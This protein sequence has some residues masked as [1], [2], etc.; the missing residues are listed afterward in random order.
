MFL[1]CSEGR[2]E[3][4]RPV[5]GKVLLLMRGVGASEAWYGVGCTG[6]GSAVTNSTGVGVAASLP[7][8]VSVLTALTRLDLTGNKLSPNSGL[9]ADY[10]ALTGLR[11]VGL[12]SM[13]LEAGPVPSSGFPQEWSSLVDL[14]QL[15]LSN[16]RLLGGT[17]PA[18]WDILASVT[19]LNIANTAACGDIPPTLSNST[20]PSTLDSYC[21]LVNCRRYLA[22][23]LQP[24]IDSQVQPGSAC[25]LTSAWPSSGRIDS[26]AGI[27][28]TAT[29]VTT[30]TPINDVMSFVLNDCYANNSNSLNVV[31]P[32]ELT[33]FSSLTELQFMRNNAAGSLPDV[34]TQLTQL[35]A[36][37]LADNILSGS[38]PASY[39]ALTGLTILKVHNNL[40]TSS[41]PPEWQAMS[42][43]EE[44][45]IS[46]NY[47]LNGT[48]PSAW[49]NLT[50]LTSFWAWGVGAG[51][52]LPPSF[53]ALS[54]L[55][56]LTFVSDTL[57]GSLPS[58]W[59]TLT[60]LTLL[61]IASDRATS[62]MT[63]TIPDVWF[64]FGGA[65]AMFALQDI[66]ISNT[67]VSGGLPTA[68]WLVTSLTKVDFSFNRLYGGASPTGFPMDYS[69]LTGLVSL[70]LADNLFLGGTV[71]SDWAVTPGSALTYLNLQNTGVCE[72]F[73]A[74]LSSAL[75]PG[76]SVNSYCDD[77]SSAYNL[78]TNFKPIFDSTTPGVGC[79]LASWDLGANPLCS[80]TWSGARCQ[81]SPA[82]S[83]GVSLGSLTSLELLNCNAGGSPVHFLPRSLTDLGGS[84]SRLAISNSAVTGTL[85]SEMVYLG[86]LTDLDL[87]GLYSLIQLN[88]GSMGLLTGPLPDS[89]AYLY[90]LEDLTI[91][92]NSLSGTLP[93]SWS[94]IYRLS[95]LVLGAGGN[96]GP[97]PS[98]N[99]AI[100]QE[101]FL[102]APLPYL[103]NLRISNTKV[104]GPLPDPGSAFTAGQL[105]LT[106]LD[107][108]SN[109]LS[110]TLPDSYQGFS[111]PSPLPPSPS[112]FAAAGS[113]VFIDVN[114]Q[115]VNL[116]DVNQTKFA[117]QSCTELQ[118][119][120]AAFNC[121]NNKLVSG[122]IIG[123][124]VLT[125]PP[126]TPLDVFYTVVQTAVT[127]DPASLFSGSFLSAPSPFAAAG[128]DVFFDVT[129]QGVNLPDV[130]QTKFAQQS[131]TELQTSTAAF[132]CV[133]NKLVSG[134]IIGG[135]VLTAPPGTPLDVFYSA[136]QTAVTTDPASL[137][138]GSFLSAYGILSVSFNVF[139]PSAL[140][141]FGRITAITFVH[142]AAIPGVVVA[143]KLVYGSGSA[144][145]TDV[146]A[147]SVY[148]PSSPTLSLST[149]RLVSSGGSALQTLSVCCT[150]TGSVAQLA[151]GF[152]DG[153]AASTGLC[154]A[155]VGAGGGSA[156]VPTGAVS[157]Q[158]AF[159]VSAK[160]DYTRIV[161]NVPPQVPNT[162]P[163]STLVLLG[164]A[165]PIVRNSLADPLI[166][167]TL[168]G[169]GRVAAFGGEK[170]ITGCC[171]PRG[172]PTPSDPSLDT[173]IV[174]AAD[175]AAWYGKK[176][177]KAIIRVADTR[178]MPMAKYVVK[179]RPDSFDTLKSAKIK[180]YYLSL[181]AFLK[182]GHKAC[183]LYV[184]GSYDIQY[185]EPRVS[186]FL[187]EFVNY[188]KGLIVVG[189]DV[190]PSIFYPGS[191]AAPSLAPSTAGRRSMLLQRAAVL[192]GDAFEPDVTDAGD[193]L[194]DPD[195]G[196][197]L[198]HQLHREMAAALVSGPMGLVF[199]GYVSD[200]G[201]N[202]TVTSPS[203]LQNAELAAS[204]YVE[205]L[206][207]RMQLTIP[208]LSLAVSTITKA[209]AVDSCLGVATNV[210][211]PNMVGTT[212]LGLQRTACFGGRELSA[213]FVAAQIAEA[214]C[215]VSCPAASNQKCGGNA[216]A[217]GI[218]VSVYRILTSDASYLTWPIVRFCL[219]AETQ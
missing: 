79:S 189:P 73:P 49:G 109:L 191:L 25:N 104:T 102:G 161:A 21:E 42:L 218:P 187:Q 166:A 167:S 91:Q 200:P 138:S 84:L 92:S 65:P 39:S 192:L 154:P 14:Q 194:S 134:S 96:A 63:G 62:T 90:S 206:Q 55:S 44:I 58:E 100:P 159:Q 86:Q 123:G 110:G 87:S 133:N 175:W 115:G 94:S 107:L 41:L 193:N 129:F 57:S 6:D 157:V 135:Y 188:G 56:E 11:L 213:S 112:P 72:P 145:H 150:A 203:E 22:E 156:G 43:L 23:T 13:D 16:N 2:A 149:V 103:W 216:N 144:T 141:Q 7:S 207:G 60:A 122:S 152:S 164:P 51:G 40:F 88:L 171:K 71:P 148:D 151:V 3:A 128:S 78:F 59:S 10:S 4:V 89:L 12:A 181:K 119:S 215:P 113:D 204:Q 153:T 170:M 163:A 101:W 197:D 36:L 127:T 18:S 126:G 117:Q 15:D 31:L 68:L 95:S 209:R 190:M 130:N 219:C 182:D 8:E 178:Y 140:D 77:L 146:L 179:K 176:V 5:P 105:G 116:P 162:V 174:N 118:T 46:D 208:E 29:T 205:Y 147:G 99:G 93:A 50:S 74:G 75:T 38:L 173:I 196:V 121:V 28:A 82:D 186:H 47:D 131:C 136:V 137:F 52:Q 214:A 143:V 67:G 48:V 139:D 212:F 32:S 180:S 114:F 217:T 202:L 160:V 211:N 19:A 125:A 198:R 45:T 184:I 34:W 210:S 70:N 124:Y 120:T 81:V 169:R 53:S 177:G 199:S 201:G 165:V 54:L 108:S 80:N 142:D 64:G 158:V 9:P 33:C 76:T 185:L 24:M 183:D 98:I 106:S 83:S 168:Y 195:A 155:G 97:G 61:N 20:T 35:Q 37:W 17:I 111:P 132:N 1:S 172:K 85:P 26:W 69:M 30:G 27:T 66:T